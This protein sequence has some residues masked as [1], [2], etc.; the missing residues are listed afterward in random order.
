M[1]IRR[2]LLGQCCVAPRERQSLKRFPSDE[3][4][5]SLVEI[6][7]A[8][9]LFATVVIVTLVLL[10]PSLGEVIKQVIDFLSK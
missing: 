5:Q 3:P 7:L 8:L 4:G 9:L 10:G 2:Q 1:R 6:A